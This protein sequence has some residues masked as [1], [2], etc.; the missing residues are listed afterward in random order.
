MSFYTTLQEI[1]GTRVLIPV[2]GGLIE[3]FVDNQVRLLNSA[4]GYPTRT[5]LQYPFRITTIGDLSCSSKEI[6][7]SI[8]IIDNF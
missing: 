6:A 7:F 8:L 4:T 1:V 2:P 3:L 5:D